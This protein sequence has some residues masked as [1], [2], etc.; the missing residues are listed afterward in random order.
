MSAPQYTLIVGLNEGHDYA[1][2]MHRHDDKATADRDLAELLAAVNAYNDYWN[3]PD[4]EA[5][6]PSDTISLHDGEVELSTVT[7]AGVY[8][9]AEWGEPS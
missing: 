7:W 4:T 2:W 1:C 9:R 8:E 5:A 6:M 3:D